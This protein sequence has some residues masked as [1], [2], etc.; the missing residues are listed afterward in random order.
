MK[1]SRISSEAGKPV[2]LKT[3]Y[4]RSGET[5]FSGDSITFLTIFLQGSAFKRLWQEDGCSRWPLKISF[6]RRKKLWEPVRIP[7]Q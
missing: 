6:E 2:N 7:F 3:D 5:L 1:P 4:M